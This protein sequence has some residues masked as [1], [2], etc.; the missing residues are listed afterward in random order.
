MVGVG[1]DP[2]ALNTHI[3]HIDR[4]SSK[5]PH[6]VR[7]LSDEQGARQAEASVATTRLEKTEAD[8]A[9]LRAELSSERSVR[10]RVNVTVGILRR[11][12]AEEKAGF[13]EMDLQFSRARAARR[14]SESQASTHVYKFNASQR[15]KNVPNP[16]S[17]RKM[18]GTYVS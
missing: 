12:L 16:F 3:T 13:Q 10:E 14:R 2:P 7:R 8:L 15:E 11:K 4:F 1:S 9:V 5:T 6:Q 18:Q 17:P